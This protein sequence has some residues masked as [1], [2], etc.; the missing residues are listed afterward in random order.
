[1]PAPEGW[2]QTWV[3]PDNYRRALKIFIKD[4][5]EDYGRNKVVDKILKDYAEGK[6]IRAG[7]IQA[8]DED[9]GG[10]GVNNDIQPPPVSPI[11][12]VGKGQLPKPNAR[13][14]SH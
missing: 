11:V 1:M 3:N 4:G 7:S 8:E 13:K 6:I 10:S 9:E 2:L 14:S 5:F 12:G